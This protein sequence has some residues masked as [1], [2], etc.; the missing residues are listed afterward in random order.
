MVGGWQNR[1]QR[2]IVHAGGLVVVGVGRDRDQLAV[3][4][5]VDGVYVRSEGI[6]VLPEVC[7][8]NILALLFLVHGNSDDTS[9]IPVEDIPR[10]WPP[11]R[12]SA[13][14]GEIP[15]LLVDHVPSAL[16]CWNKL[17]PLLLLFSRCVQVPADARRCP[18]K[19]SCVW[20]VTAEAEALSS[21]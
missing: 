4:R 3:L 19:I 11:G 10:A 15:P 18:H 21:A 14:G 7:D 8:G 13:A 17:I 1:P 9:L 5:Y 20:L 2:R 12:E 6:D 16:F